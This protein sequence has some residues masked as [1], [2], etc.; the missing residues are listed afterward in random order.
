M[1]R[2][3]RN[4]KGITVDLSG[5]ETSGNI[6]EGSYLVTVDEVS[7][8]E[9]RNSGKPYIKFIFEVAEGDSKGFKLFH[10]C[11]LQP[12]ALFNLKAVLMALGFD[13]PNQAFDLD[14]DELV[15][16]SCYVEVAHETYEGKKRPRI[17]EFESVDGDSGG[18]DYS[19]IEEQLDDLDFDE[20]KELAKELG[21]KA[22]ALKK[23]EDEDDVIDLIFDYDD[24][25]IE[26]ALDELFSDEDDEDD[27]EDDENDKDDY[28]D[29]A[30]EDDDEDNDGGEDYSDW[31]TKELKAEC[32]DRGIKVRK[33]MKKED[34][35][36][37]LEEDD[38]E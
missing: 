29:E 25:D 1:A 34:L 36:E 35:I 8:E 23:A 15:G 9:S 6:K 38:E 27:E 3:N 18:D 26:E 10:N 4:K 16:L 14:L 32:K 12:Q 19:D 30:D 24:E 7:L 17:V 20:L 13:I 21:V 5:V 33:G 31:T 11:S 37:L 2:R 22:G 28:E